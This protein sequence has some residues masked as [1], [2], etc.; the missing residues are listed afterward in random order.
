MSLK[1]NYFGNF[2]SKR[3]LGTIYLFASSVAGFVPIFI[4]R[5]LDEVIFSRWLSLLYF[6]DFSVCL[7]MLVTTWF[8]F[9]WWHY[10]YRH[11]SVFNCLFNVWLRSGHALRFYRHL[12]LR[13]AY[14]CV[15][16]DWLDIFGSLWN[17]WP[18][19]ILIRFNE[20]Q[21]FFNFLMDGRDMIFHWILS[22]HRQ[23]Q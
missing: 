21:N 12:T 6:F 13:K 17:V 9:I 1:S 4:Q 18:V 5:V 8:S 11:C 20:V 2:G 16:F 15:A 22:E 19:V 23:N 7:C 14:K 10:C 3:W